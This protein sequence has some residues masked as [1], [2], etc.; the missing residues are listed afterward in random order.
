MFLLACVLYDDNKTPADSSDLVDSA[1]PAE[2]ADSETDPVETG[3]PAETAET[4][5]T[6]D[7]AP[8]ETDTGET[9][10]ETGDSGTTTVDRTGVVVADFS[11]PDVNP[12]SPSYGE[13][14]SPRDHLYQVSGWYFIH[15]T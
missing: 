3:D 11:L 7:S 10:I 9:A 14:I 6:V 8:T 13:T 15:A 5:D 2:T 12:S 1:D 4:A